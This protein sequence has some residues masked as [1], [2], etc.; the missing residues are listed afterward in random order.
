MPPYLRSDGSP[1]TSHD[2]LNLDHSCRRICVAVCTRVGCFKGTTPPEDSSRIQCGTTRSTQFCR[3]RYAE[4]ASQ[5]SPALGSN[6]SRPLNHQHQDGCYRCDGLLPHYSEYQ[7]L[8]I[9]P[10]VLGGPKA[11]RGNEANGRAAITRTSLMGR[12]PRR[13]VGRIVL[14]GVGR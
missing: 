10:G 6:P 12:S 11:L 9:A 4:W 3:F 1:G 13:E 2:C 5:R 14:T 7:T 8:M